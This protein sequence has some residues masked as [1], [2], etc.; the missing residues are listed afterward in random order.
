MSVSHKTAR[1]RQT[2]REGSKFLALVQ[3]VEFTSE[4][5]NA[6]D[7]D[8]WMKTQHVQRTL[9]MMDDLFRWLW[10]G[11]G[12]FCLGIATPEIKT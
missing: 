2:A 8:K 7:V 9:M 11:G 6:M 3:S 5:M 4:K 10:N 12:M 1:P